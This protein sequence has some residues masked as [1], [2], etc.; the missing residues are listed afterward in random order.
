MKGSHKLS[1]VC[2]K[3]AANTCIFWYPACEIV[4]LNEVHLVQAVRTFSLK[5]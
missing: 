3:C 4:T 5:L 1:T 2:R